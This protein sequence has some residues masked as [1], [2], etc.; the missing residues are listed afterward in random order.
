MQAYHC[1]GQRVRTEW[2]EPAL[3]TYLSI[4]QRSI[5]AIMLASVASGQPGAQAQSIIPPP[6]FL[7]I[8]NGH[9]EGSS[10][11]LPSCSETAHRLSG[12]LKSQNYNV[13]E[14]LNP[15]SVELRVSLSGFARHVDNKRPVIA[16]CGMAWVQNDRIFLSR[17]EQKSDLLRNA[18][19]ADSLIRAADKQNGF[20]FLELHPVPGQS[21][22]LSRA[23]ALLKSRTDT[24]PS[25]TA[26]IVQSPAADPVIDE[27]TSAMQP[28]WQ[29]NNLA[30]LTH[31]NG[32]N[33]KSNPAPDTT[34]PS[35]SAASP[36]PP[37]QA[38]LPSVPDSQDPAPT[39]SSVTAT[40][41]ST[42][43]EVS[44][45][46]SAAVN[47]NTSQQ[48]TA[49][50]PPSPPPVKKENT[51]VVKAREKAVRQLQVN[52]LARGY[53]SGVINGIKT[54]ETINAIKKF[55]KSM[56]APQTGNL[57]DYQAAALFSAVH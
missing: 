9:T 10:T 46:P 33:Q 11:I 17:D 35:P 3:P 57:T 48:P 15:S 38:P 23:V 36:V 4:C 16:Y 53:Y 21:Q 55:Q 39:H 6:T 37:L 40:D 14:V 27:L 26:T 22:E 56:H 1:T 20:V 32:L 30:N 24:S 54:P 13:F 41:T 5:A 25:L 52:L 29:W 45:S 43:K 47:N 34:I 18:V 2:R 31:D 7:I 42:V 28:G 49:V 44:P 50:T 19:V 12:Q 51:Q 8:G